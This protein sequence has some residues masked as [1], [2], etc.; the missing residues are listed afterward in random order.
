MACWVHEKN[1]GGFT[2]IDAP[3]KADGDD[4]AKAIAILDKELPKADRIALAVRGP[5]ACCGW[6]GKYLQYND[7]EADLEALAVSTSS[8]LE[9]LGLETAVEIFDYTMCVNT[10]VDHGAG[11]QRKNISI[12]S[13]AIIVR[14]KATKE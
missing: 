14:K 9:A 10:G 8:Q 4:E 5:G 6:H 7:C 11:P 12:S 13:M 2:K 1:R 3:R